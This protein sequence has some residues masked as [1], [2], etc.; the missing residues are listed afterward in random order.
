MG[1]II[2]RSMCPIYPQPDSDDDDDDTIYDETAPIKPSEVMEREYRINEKKGIE[3]N[4][5]LRPSQ[6]MK[7]ENE[8]LRR[9]NNT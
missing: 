6:I 7:M 5:L 1:N 2:A 9:L 4:I 3:S 8:K